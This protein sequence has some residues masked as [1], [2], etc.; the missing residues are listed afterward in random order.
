M[1]GISGIVA[2]GLRIDALQSRIKAMNRAMRH[3]GPD[4]EGCFADDGV[5]LGHM[6]LTII[7]LTD[8]GAQPMSNEDG[9]LQLVVNGEIYNHQQLRRQLESRGHSFGSHSDSEVVL[10]LYEEYGIDALDHLQGMFALALWDVRREQLLLARDRFGIKPLYYAQI[11]DRL[12]FASELTALQASGFLD[13]QLDPLAIYQYMTLSYIPAPLTVFSVAK[14][15]RPAERLRFCRGALHTETYWSPQPVQVPSSFGEGCNQLQYQLGLSVQSHLCA[16]VPVAG[17]L[18]GG[19][20]SSLIDA[21][22]QQRQSMHTLCAAFPGENIDESG[23][24]AEV[25]A[26]I[27][28]KHQTIA[29]DVDPSAL[30]SNISGQFDEPFADSSAMPTYVVCRAGRRMAKVML[31][32]DG[33]DEGFGGYTGRY[34]SSALSAL[35]PA[36]QLFASLLRQLPPW[37]SGRRSSLPAML[38]MAAL[39]PVSRY[40]RD[41][42]ITTLPQRQRLFSAQQVMEGEDWLRQML[43]QQRQA[44]PWSHPVSQAL[45]LD[46][47]TSLSDDMLTK[48]DR[49]SMAHGLEVRVPLLDHN[50]ITFAL[51]CPPHWLVSARGIEGKRMLRSVAAPMLPGGILDRPK[52]GFVV[53]LDAWLAGPL[54]SL[55]RDSDHSMLAPWLDLEAFE[56]ADLPSP[57]GKSRE[58]RYA[59]LMLDLWLQCQQERK[60]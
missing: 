50:L 12:L 14:K 22:A 44:S 8:S 45:W 23:L 39:D 16:D 3:R 40:I 1:C 59:L 29:V 31:S 48:V 7:D 30:L 43:E 37:R 24:A 53:P 15:L 21:M 35:L 33:G 52:Q 5:A 28:S 42:Q 36:P 10:H 18:S 54:A 55:W 20:D 6:R 49:M 32:G 11:G 4:G 17:F 38:D 13:D 56:C 26:H 27:G 25:A 58:D 57:Q 51:S 41:H 2:P 47:T 34:R 19:V 60:S 46:L 9:S